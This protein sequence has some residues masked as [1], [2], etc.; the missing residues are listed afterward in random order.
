MKRIAVMITERQDM[1]IKNL[2][3][4]L[5][6]QFSEMLRR[7]LDTSL[8]E[9]MKTALETQAL[10]DARDS[11]ATKAR[12]ESPPLRPLSKKKSNAHGNP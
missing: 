9:T 12:A 10:M 7:L 1:L 4:N 5:G 2:A 11:G 6:I 3:E 8:E